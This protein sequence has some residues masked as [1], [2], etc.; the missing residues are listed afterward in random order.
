MLC[1]NTLFFQRGISM[2]KRTVF[3]LVVALAATACQKKATGQ[4]VAVVNGEEITASEL[5]DA[6]TNDNT[7]AVLDPKQARAAELQKLVDRKLIVQQAKENGLD[8]TP[9]FI[10]QQRRGTEDLLIN[11][12]VSRQANSQQIPSAADIAKFEADRPGMFA[13]REKWTLNMLNYPLPKDPA[14]TAK[15]AAAKSLDDVAQ[16]LTAAGIQYTKSTKEFDSALLPPAIYAQL[17]KLQPGE[18]FVV[19]GPDR[20]V[21]SVITAREPAPFT[22]DQAR[23]LALSQI[24]REQINALLG[25]RIKELKAKAKI[26]YQPGFAPPKN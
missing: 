9:E 11:M 1:A 6:L 8:K 22:P 4:S 15:I 23:Q 2:R 5:N 3:T 21:A 7:L 19:P 13:N 20:A 14:V 25:Q 18:P 24:K 16:A 12:L 10:N 17:G 26:E